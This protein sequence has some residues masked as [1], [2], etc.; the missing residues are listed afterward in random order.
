MTSVDIVITKDGT[1][2]THVNGI[3]GPK[4]ENTLDGLVKKCKVLKD[5]K[6]PDYYKDGGGDVRI[7][8]KVSK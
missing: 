7:D 3:K 1:I 2:K 8:S 4:C 5:T 6:T